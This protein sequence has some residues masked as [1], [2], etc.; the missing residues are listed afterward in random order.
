MGDFL[1]TMARF[2]PVSHYARR[3]SP[4]VAYRAG[5]AVP[6]EGSKRTAPGAVRKLGSSPEAARS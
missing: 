4:L 3:F 5:S 1:P 6:D 2:P